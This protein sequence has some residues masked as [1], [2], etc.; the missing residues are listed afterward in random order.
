MYTQ[1]STT[2]ELTKEQIKRQKHNEASKKWANSHP[3][4]KHQANQ[5]W[6]RNNSTYWIQHTQEYKRKNPMKNQAH[7]AVKIAL[8]KNEI[9]DPKNLLCTCGSV[10][11]QYHHES[12]A[13]KDW[14]NVIAL[15]TECHRQLHTTKK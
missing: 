7:K 4:K 2:T 8:A 5:K 3:E 12:Y 9:P 1:Q 10:A 11:E 13:P 6:Y 14:L 15:C